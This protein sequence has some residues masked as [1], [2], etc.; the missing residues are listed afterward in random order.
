MRNLILIVLIL[1][2]LPVLAVAQNSNKP[3]GRGATFYFKERPLETQL[4]SLYEQFLEAISKGDIETYQRLTTDT[5]VF[6]RGTSG[7]VLFKEQRL[8]QLE[9]EAKI[10]VGFD[11]TSAKFAIYKDSAVGIFDLTE[12]DVQQDK[13]Y[14]YPLRVTVFFVK[15]DNKDWQIAAV[16][17]TPVAK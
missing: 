2:T 1:I 6:T 13:P 17:S 12:K 11:M 5:Y 16:H 7:E 10:I 4:K 14:S 3:V 15:I 8:K 9:A